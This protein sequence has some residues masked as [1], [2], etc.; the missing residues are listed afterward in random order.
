MD[1]VGRALSAAK[2]SI[3]LCSFCPKEPQGKVCVT[4]MQYNSAFSCAGPCTAVH[5]RFENSISTCVVKSGRNC[6]P[7]PRSAGNQLKRQGFFNSVTTGN[8]RRTCTVP[9]S[10][11]NSRHLDASNSTAK[12][13]S[14]PFLLTIRALQ[15]LNVRKMGMRRKINVPWGHQTW[16]N[17]VY[18][19]GKWGCK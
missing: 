11:V 12:M 17:V 6:T 13:F 8:V 15:R 14:Y 16:M 9:R 4:L 2:N 1:Q 3:L 5:R 19:A 7:L 18:C 10:L